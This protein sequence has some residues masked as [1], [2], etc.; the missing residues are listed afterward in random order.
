MS[1]GQLQVVVRHLRRLVGEAGSEPTD[2]ELLARFA[3]THDEAAFAALVQRHGS[4]VWGVCRRRL[5]HLQDAEDVFQATFLVLARKAA[6]VRW[7][8]SVQNWLY[9]VA[10]RLAAEARLKAAR[11]QRHEAAAAIPAHA[12]ALPS[13][14]GRELASVLDEELQL[15]PQ[16]Y[17]TPLLLCYLDGQTSDQAARQLG[18]SL[19]TLQRR[20]AQGR[21]LL[22]HRLTRR[23]ITLSAAL[24]APALSEGAVPVSLATTTVRLAVSFAAGSTATAGGVIALVKPL[25]KEMAMTRF[26]IAAIFLVLGTLVGVGTLLHS[27]VSPAAPTP[28]TPDVPAKKDAPAKEAPP[29]PALLAQRLWA[30]MDLVQ[31]K[32]PDPPPRAAMIAA[33]AE[34]VLKAARITV[35]DDLARRAARVTTREQFATFLQQ[36]W[37]R[38]AVEPP[39]DQL[40]QAAINGLF[41]AVP[42]QG[43]FYTPEIA[44]GFEAANANR[45]VGIGI[46]I[47]IHDQEKLPQIVS[48]VGRGPARR[49]GIEPGDL[50]VEVDGKSTRDVPLARVVEWLRG[51]LDTTFLLTVRSPGSD[52]TRVLKMT[53]SVVPFETVMGYRRAP[54]D[55]W[56]FRIDPREPIGYVRLEGF[57]SSTPHELRQL[58]RRFRG[59]GLRALVLD[60]RSSG[61]GSDLHNGTLVASALLD[62][63]VLWRL[64]GADKQ[65]REYRSGR[66]G[67]FRDWP[68]VALINDQL[69]SSQGAVAAALQ[70]N[71]RA[72]LVG[73]ATRNGG[74]VTSVLPL[75]DG[76]G[77]LAFRTG[78]LERAARDRTWPVQPDHAVPLTKAQQQA[79]Q[80]WLNAKMHLEKPG[81]EADKA[82][83]DPQRDKAV[84]LLRAA[85]KKADETR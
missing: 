38:D 77:A 40:E 74:F 28:Q 83:D 69:D 15:L 61:G 60:L 2:R 33:A 12:A 54:D 27:S 45:Y 57:R 55:G 31:E 36:V 56:D 62:G 32:H 51:E 78:R 68:L 9:E 63:G 82:P 3:G 26:K 25:L 50:I 64:R 67:L 35:P 84:E 43:E 79:V 5:R 53:R 66:E 75:P 41:A 22:R 6:V 18:W 8:N 29:A 11:R 13:D 20:L 1:Q 71:G 23:G 65:L 80:Q 30:M 34:A 48:P 44:K 73:E 10:C 37:P 14:A 72:I 52:K 21:E 39:A 17:R 58:E 49:A 59:E 76:Q 42:G 7:R 4:L 85:L 24:L 46:Q 70:D 16:R 81:S 19:R 47:R